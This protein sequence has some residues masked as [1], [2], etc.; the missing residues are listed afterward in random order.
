MASSQSLNTK[1]GTKVYIKH[2][3][4]GSTYNDRATWKLKERMAKKIKQLDIRMDTH[5]RK[6]AWLD[7]DVLFHWAQGGIN[8]SQ[9]LQIGL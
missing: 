9:V 1:I 7:S 3:L 8:R 4:K 5:W 2:S 6:S